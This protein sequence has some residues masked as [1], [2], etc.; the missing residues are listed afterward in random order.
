MTVNVSELA[1]NLGL[2][3]STVSRALRH[4][5]LVAKETRE[6]ILEAARDAGM[7][8]ESLTEGRRL[9]SGL[10][11][12]LVADLHNAFSGEIVAAVSEVAYA[13]DF[14]PVVGCTYERAGEES[15]I[16]RQW[17]NLKLAGLV[18]MPTA[19]F[20]KNA[21]LLEELPVIAVDRD[22]TGFECD[23]VLDDN[24]EGMRLAIDHLRE[25]GHQRIAVL[26]GSRTVY[27]FK[28]RAAAAAAYAPDLEIIEVNAVAYEELYMGAFEQVNI[29]SLRD[30]RR[31]PTA[32]IATNNALSAGTLYAA[33]LRGIRIP[34]DLS[35]VAFGDSQWMRFYPVP[36]T[37]V[38]Q[39]VTA[40]GTAAAQ[41]LIT[42]IKGDESPFTLEVLHP[43]LMP[44]SS[45]GV[46][47]A[48]S[49][50]SY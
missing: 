42:R 15:H 30:S 20:A 43:M 25:L 37:A 9:R 28:E 24:A 6:R 10:I 1:R 3:A 38:R 4:P 31:R 7:G 49:S 8:G 2:S 46:P 22:V 45:S 13:H 18:V 17:R 48:S 50:A 47:G 40:M 44:R 39:P 29:L 11:G 21:E 34:D 5:E 19:H 41:K 36:V 33:N 35:M 16:L 12:V 14:I 26:A 23:R 32:I 27:T